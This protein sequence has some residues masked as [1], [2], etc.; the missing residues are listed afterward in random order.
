MADDT[1]EV[2]E[3]GPPQQ[4]PPP[5]LEVVC[6][7]SGKRRRFAAGAEAGFAVRVMNKKLE[8][9]SPFALY[10]EAVK[11][12]EEAVAFGPNSA[13]VDYGSGWRLQTVIEVDYT[14]GDKGEGFQQ[15]MARS[16][17][18]NT[19]GSRVAKDVGKPTISLVYV[20]KILVAFILIF[21]LGAIF[22]LALEYLPMLILSIKSFM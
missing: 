19:D 2:S 20:G 13:L 11:E 3:V 18:R 22:T 7:S 15:R 10:I 8:G 4:L 5:F 1:E 12:G 21:V 14:G 9:G 6:R 17:L 16:P